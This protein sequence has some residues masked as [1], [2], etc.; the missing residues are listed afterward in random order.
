MDII[1]S[2][3]QTVFQAYNVARRKLWALRNRSRLRTN[4]Q[5]IFKPNGGYCACFPSNV[6]QNM[7]FWKLRKSF[8]SFSWEIFSHLMCLDQSIQVK[9]W[10]IVRT[11][12]P[13][14]TNTVK[15]H[16]FLATFCFSFLYFR[17]NFNNNNYSTCTCSSSSSFISHV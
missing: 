8:V 7:L 13:C 5:A 1:Y 16:N 4:I 6:S 11:I 12:I 15:I 3:K 10:W 14:S 9:I 17:G 2:K